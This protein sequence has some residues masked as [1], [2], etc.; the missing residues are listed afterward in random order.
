MILS[1]GIAVFINY[2]LQT[3]IYEAET[4][5]LVNQKKL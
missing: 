5:L 1:I 3:P 2:F 4:Q